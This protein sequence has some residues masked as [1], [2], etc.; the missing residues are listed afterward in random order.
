MWS[1]PVKIGLEVVVAR[2]EVR[3]GNKA[4]NG[5]SSYPFILPYLSKAIWERE[6]E[7]G[8]ILC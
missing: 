3:N 8:T 2:E 7:K 5:S 1:L 4:S 6:R